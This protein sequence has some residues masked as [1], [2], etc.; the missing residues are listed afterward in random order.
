[1][2]PP[3]TLFSPILAKPV[4]Q[5]RSKFSVLRGRINQIDLV[6]WSRPTPTSFSLSD[7]ILRY[8]GKNMEGNWPKQE[9]SK[10]CSIGCCRKRIA[11]GICCD[12]Q[13]IPD[14][15]SP[16]KL[17]VGLKTVEIGGLFMKDRDRYI[18]RIPAPFMHSL[19][20]GNGRL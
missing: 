11:Q 13:T 10:C 19:P 17:S 7:V 18:A 9:R 4:R 15:R 20:D 5:R 1:M 2:P 12:P 3:L 14:I 8:Y 16:S 6:R